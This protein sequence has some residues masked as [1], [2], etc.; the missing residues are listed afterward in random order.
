M[1][2]LVYSVRASGDGRRIP[3]SS[4]RF[5]RC[6]ASLIA[7]GRGP[8]SVDALAS[9]LNETMDGK[10]VSAASLSHGI[11]GAVKIPTKYGTPVAAVYGLEGQER[12]TFD[13]LRLAAQLDDRDAARLHELAGVP[14]TDL[15]FARVE[16]PDD[17]VEEKADDAG[18]GDG[19]DGS[20]GVTTDGEAAPPVAVADDGEAG[21]VA[22]EGQPDE[23]QPAA[24]SDERPVAGDDAA[25]DED[26]A[27]NGPTHIRA[28]G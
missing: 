11:R 18:S 24:T 13:V 21:V 3:S 12:N 10:E 7:S 1:P 6:V 17:V 16:V 26:D 8:R 28:E 4:L 2:K 14:V 19:G 22:D 15:V 27:S 25:A 9:V 23:G 20:V 5:S